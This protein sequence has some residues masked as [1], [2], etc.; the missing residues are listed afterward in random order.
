MNKNTE[1]ESFTEID[2]EK[3]LIYNPAGF[4]I[5]LIVAV[6]L[7]VMM[8]SYEDN[9]FY[10]IFDAAATFAGI[11]GMASLFG[12]LLR[13][14]GNYLIAIVVFIAACVGYGK[15]FDY[16]TS[17]GLA[18]EVIFDIVFM[19]VLIVVLVRDIRK[20]ILYFKYTR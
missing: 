8:V 20:T 18:L 19:L 7:T 10:T 2:E 13:A 3:I 6:A 4:V 5:K 1:D 15:L 17:S 11:Y 14:T 9:L 12:F 16:V